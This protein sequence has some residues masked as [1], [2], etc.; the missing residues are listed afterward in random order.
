VVAAALIDDHGRVLLTQRPAGSHLAGTWEFPGGK[1]EPEEG[2]RDALARELAEEL[3]VRAEIGP[4]VAEIEHPYE[5]FVVHL[6]LFA[7]VIRAGTPRAVEVADLRW[8]RLDE[9]RTLPMPPADGPLIDALEAY[10]VRL[11]K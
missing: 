1:R 8:V 6:R 11:T 2:D 10:L 7:G 9:M 5:R 4:L 3:D